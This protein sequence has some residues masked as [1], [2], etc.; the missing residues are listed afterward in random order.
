MPHVTFPPL[1]FPLFVRVSTKSSAPLLTDIHEQQARFAAALL[2]HLKSITRER[3]Q[4]LQE[5]PIGE[6]PCFLVL[7][8]SLQ[9]HKQICTVRSVREDGNWAENPEKQSIAITTRI[10][11]A[12]EPGKNVCLAEKNQNQNPRRRDWKILQKKE[13]HKNKKH[14]SATIPPFFFRKK[15]TI[16]FRG[17]LPIDSLF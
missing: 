7:W 17:G 9:W 15:L 14:S 1:G 4:S 6:N 8:K 3:A 16:L 11:I 10:Y 13:I 12:V 5:S 2:T